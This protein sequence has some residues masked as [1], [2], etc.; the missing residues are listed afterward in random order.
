L[1]RAG[2]TGSA[3]NPIPLPSPSKEN[4]T[5]AKPKTSNALKAF[6]IP[7]PLSDIITTPVKAK[8]VRPVKPA[9]STHA[10]SQKN[11][12]QPGTPAGKKQRGLNSATME[13]FMRA[14]NKPGLY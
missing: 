11:L 1:E 6:D 8:S 9:R 5:V 7:D 12:T 2:T 14:R 13:S 10:K 4:D 3:T